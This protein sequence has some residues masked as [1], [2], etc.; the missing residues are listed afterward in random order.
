MS[1]CI[2]P[3]KANIQEG[4]VTFRNKEARSGLTSLSQAPSSPP[5]VIQGVDL[6]FLANLLIT[7]NLVPFESPSQPTL[8]RAS[9]REPQLVHEPPTADLVSFLAT[10]PSSL[11]QGA[12]CNISN[13][14]KTLIG[15]TLF[16]SKYTHTQSFVCLQPQQG[17]SISIS[18]YLHLHL[19]RH[20]H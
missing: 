9:R 13:E 3:S 6:A 19:L 20:R 7:H 18:S 17:F 5:L 16:T 1:P 8:Q 10:T 4:L 11:I 2:C 12:P 14:D 15:I